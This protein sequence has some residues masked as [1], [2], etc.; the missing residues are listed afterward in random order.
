MLRPLMPRQ[1][2]PDPPKVFILALEFKSVIRLR[3]HFARHGAVS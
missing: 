1:E 3:S 2:R